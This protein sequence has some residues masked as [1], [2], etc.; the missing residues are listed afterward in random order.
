MFGE[1]PDVLT[2]RTVFSFCGRLVG[3]LPVCDWLRVAV[4]YIKRHSS[5]ST[6]DEEMCDDSVRA[7]LEDCV[8]RVKQ[9]DPAKGHWNVVGEEATVWVDASSLALGV[10]IEVNGQVV[11][12]AS[13]LRSED[14]SFHIN[15]AELDAVIKGVNTALAWKLKKLHLRTDSLTV[16]HWISDALSGKARL[17]TKASSEMLLRRRINTVK[18]LVDEYDLALDIEH[19]R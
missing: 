14:A 13:W 19:V 11:E 9:D 12:D 6:W 15:M 17:K 7:M 4:A 8:R 10:A 18:A 2:K 16:Y 5:T 1:I 3:H